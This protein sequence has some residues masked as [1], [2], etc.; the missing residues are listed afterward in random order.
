[1]SI[2]YRT[3]QNLKHITIGLAILLIFPSVIYKY[4]II[5][6]MLSKCYN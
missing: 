5:D 2:P 1:M 3:Q 4:K 6:K